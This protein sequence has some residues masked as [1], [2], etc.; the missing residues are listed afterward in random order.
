MIAAQ[1]T[2][3]GKV[4]IENIQE[5]PSLEPTEVLVQVVSVGICGSDV[6]N[7]A[8]GGIGSRK[9]SYPFIPGHEASGIILEAGSAVDNCEVGDRVMIEPAMHCGDCDQCKL[10]RFN[11]CR[12]IQFLSSAG[13]LQGCMCERIVSLA[14]NAFVVP[15]ETDP[16]LVALAEPLSVAIHSVRNSLQIDDSLSIA[17]LGAGPIGLCTLIAL[18]EAGAEKVYMTDPIPERREMART[19]GAHWVGEPED[20][21]DLLPL[22]MQLVFECSGKPDGL[23]QA[24]SI[25]GPGGKLIITGIP[26]SNE[27]TLDI[28]QL[29]RKEI[30]IFN[31]RRQNQCVQPALNM[32]ATCADKLKR[33]VTH[34]FDLLD[35]QEAFEM[36]HAYGD[37][38]IKAMINCKR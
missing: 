24:V 29:R 16:D 33:L 26:E 28:S 30:S 12:N 23:A 18:Q 10:G 21:N 36:V 37:G 1:L 27:I 32:I 31:V 22:G 6:H 25:V 19:L 14:H 7:F 20:L 2:G 3:V 8:E 11:T 15:A 17:V 35:T 9:V 5:P 38:V 4:T 13:E 34:H